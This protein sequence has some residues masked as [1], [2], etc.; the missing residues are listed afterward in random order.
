MTLRILGMHIA[1]Y[2]WYFHSRLPFS[3][4]R[5]DNTS[6]HASPHKRYP[7]NSRLGIPSPVPMPQRFFQLL[8]VLK[9]RRSK[10][11]TYLD[12]DLATMFDTAEGRYG[13]TGNICSWIVDLKWCRLEWVLGVISLGGLVSSSASISLDGRN[14]IS[15]CFSVPILNVHYPLCLI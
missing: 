4:S 1:N 3:Q 12:L 6:A 9:S 13:R 14:A 15:C 2:R 11:A 8:A 7:F 10:S 5:E